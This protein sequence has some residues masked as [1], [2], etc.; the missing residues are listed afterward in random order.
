MKRNNHYEK[1]STRN[2]SINARKYNIGI[3]RLPLADVQEITEYED[4]TDDNST[5]TNKSKETP[6]KKNKLGWNK[7]SEEKLF[8]RNV[9]KNQ[10]TRKEDSS[11]YSTDSVSG[12]KKKV[13]LRGGTDFFRSSLVS[14]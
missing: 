12:T 9:K 13:R 7:N 3:S 10:I 8:N 11:T 14:E 1:I 2:R 4:S 5:T 6:L